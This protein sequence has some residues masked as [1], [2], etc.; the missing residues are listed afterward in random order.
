MSMLTNLS[1]L[2][3]RDLKQ[4]RC[5]LGRLFEIPQLVSNSKRARP[6]TSLFDCEICVYTLDGRHRL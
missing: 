4:L 3:P 5:R 2:V 1:L 6:T